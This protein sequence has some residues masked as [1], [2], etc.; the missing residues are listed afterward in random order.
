MGLDISVFKDVKF[1]DF[2][3]MVLPQFDNVK[4]IF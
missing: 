1:I 4:N 2:D 3:I